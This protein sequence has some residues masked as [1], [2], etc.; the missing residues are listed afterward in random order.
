MDLLYK[1]QTR[2]LFHAHIKIKISVFYEESIFDELFAILEEVDKKYNSYQS[3]SYI[4]RINK[5]AGSFVEVDDETVRILQKTIFWADFFDGEFDITVMPLIRL[6]GFYKNENRKI[7]NLAEIETA[8][9]NIDYK[10]IEIEGNNVRIAEG[11]EIITGSFIKAYAVDKLVEQMRNIG[12]NDAIVNAG[13]ST[14]YAIN[15]SDSHPFWKINV[16]DAET[17]ELRDTFHI[18]NKCYTTSSQSETFLDIDGRRYGHILN[19]NSG[20]PST[21]K[22]IGIVTDSCIDG[23]I[24]ST[25]LFNQSLRGF[26]E[27]MIRIKEIIDADGFIIDESNNVFET[28][29]LTKLRVEK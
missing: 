17:N 7:P 3:G 29:G 25:G 24:I 21:N 8:K 6:W 26:E 12:I 2:F 28:T 23:D 19:P 1:A 4:D 15:N 10:K 5:N 13:G 14:I 27:K 16:R 11:Q 18:G 22:Q 9:R 20:Y